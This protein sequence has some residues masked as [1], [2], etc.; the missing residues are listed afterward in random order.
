[1]PNEL[2]ITQKRIDVSASKVIYH[3]PFN[4]AVFQRDWI[5]RSGQWEVRDGAMWGVNPLAQ[6]GCVACRRALGGNV[7][8]DFHARTVAPS[9]H[10]IDVMWNFSWDEQADQRGTAYVAGLAG[11]W[12]KK[13]GF[14]RSP[15]YKLLCVAPCPWFVPG[16][17][18]HVQVGSID[19]H[20]FIFV[21]GELRLEMIDPQPIDSSK[22]VNVGFE[23]YQSQVCITDLQVR[24]IAWE[25]HPQSYLQEF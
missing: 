1:M 14:E 5:V 21:D 6:A 2:L 20:C 4:P 7:M 16:K 18:Y 23:A 8:L 25:P 17:L 13:I 22:H 24:Q 3:E 12:D 15:E 11:W 19:G 9:T 10:D